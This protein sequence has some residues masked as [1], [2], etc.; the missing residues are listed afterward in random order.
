MKWGKKRKSSSRPFLTSQVLPTSWLTKFKQMSMN[1]GEKQAKMK[2]KGKWN[3]VTTN[4]SS[5][6]T[7]TTGVGKFYGGDGDAF[8]RLS[9]GEDSLEGM[10]S[11]GVFKSVRYNSDDDDNDLEFPPSSFQSYSRVNEKEAQKFSD[12]VSHARKMRGLPKEIEIFPRVQTC[13]REKVAEIRTPRLGV[14]REKTLRKGNY[15]VFED[16]QLEGRQAEAEKHPRKA[17]AKNMYERKPGKFV[18]G[19]DVK[20]AAADSRDSYLREIEEDCSLCAEKESDGFY[21]ENHSY[22]WQKLK[23]RKIEEVKSRKEE[24]RKSVYISRD[25]ERKTKQNNKVKVNSPR[26]ASKAEI[27]KI[28]A[29]EDMKKA[30]LKAKKKAKGKTVEEFQGLESF[31]VVKCSYDPQKDFR[32]S[33][34]EMIKEQNISRSEELEE[35]LACYLTL[36]SDEYHDLIIRVFRQV[37][38]DLNQ[39]SFVAN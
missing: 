11:R 1:S 34:V 16:K 30:K 13:I 20:L 9:F 14:E 37:W 24:Q 36:N 3:S 17:V 26:T 2:Q 5:Y 21:A 35:L 22:K 10:K 29:L 7:N 39:A 33:M 32:D 19:E 15:G 6:A 25:V 38:F 28:K 8:W 23:E 31:A 4:P 18:E 27:C 12:M